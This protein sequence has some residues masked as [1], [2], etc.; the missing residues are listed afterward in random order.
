MIFRTVLTTLLLVSVGAS[1]VAPKA[2]VPSKPAFTV[3]PI[4]P[5]TGEA[6]IVKKEIKLSTKQA[7]AS[8]L[9]LALNSGFMNGCCLSGA[10]ALDGTKQAVAAVTGAYTGS[11]VAMASGNGGAAMN[12]FKVL[13]SYIAG[14]MAAG[15]LNPNPKTFQVAKGVGPSLLLGSVLLFTSKSLLSNHQNL[16]AFCLIA[17]ANGLQNSMTSVHTANLCRTTHYTGISSDMGTFLGQLLRGNKA[18]AMKLKVF[19]GLAAS[20][21]LGGFASVKVAGKMCEN[22]LL[23]PAYFYLVTGLY[24]LGL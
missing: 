6:P 5:A 15:L 23:L 18:N 21:W 19:A 20:F 12:T 7:V 3:T 14:A 17:A 22:A 11:A 1:N 8:G 10:V 16:L 4:D 2:P 13:G 24:F 9:A